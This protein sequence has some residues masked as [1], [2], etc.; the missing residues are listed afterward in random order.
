MYVNLLGRDIDAETGIPY[1][2]DGIGL[3]ESGYSYW[4]GRLTMLIQ[5]NVKLIMKSY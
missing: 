4:V 5:A 1:N 2:A 3:D